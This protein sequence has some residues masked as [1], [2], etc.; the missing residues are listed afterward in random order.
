MHSAINASPCASM[1]QI[2]TL[3]KLKAVLEIGF[4]FAQDFYLISSEFSR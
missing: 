1:K 2:E 3:P 4:G